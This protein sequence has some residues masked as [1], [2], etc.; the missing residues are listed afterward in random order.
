M[1]N[2]I[3][4]TFF[5]LLLVGAAALSLA[6][7]DR[8][9]SESEKRLLT[10]RE[11]LKLEEYGSGKFQSTLDQYLTDQ[12]PGRNGW[13]LPKDPGPT[14]AGRQAGGGRRVLCP[15]RLPDPEV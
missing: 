4:T 10:Q 3:V 13:N 7:P 15:G 14:L 6:L 9:Y 12:F 5:C 2:K 11:E 1:R 8:Y